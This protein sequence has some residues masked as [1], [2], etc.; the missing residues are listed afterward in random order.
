MENIMLFSV[1]TT[2]NNFKGSLLLIS[3][4]SFHLGMLN[5]SQKLDHGGF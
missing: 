2:K 3:C 1:L 4:F 5:N